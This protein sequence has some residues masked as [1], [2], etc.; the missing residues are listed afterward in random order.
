MER[1]REDAA[2]LHVLVVVAAVGGEHDPAALRRHPHALQPGRMAA[3]VM[4]ADARREL[5]RRR[6]GKGRDP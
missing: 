1:G 5:G 6:H 2:G 3:D 4:H